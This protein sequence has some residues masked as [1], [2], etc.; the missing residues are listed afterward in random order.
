MISSVA[1]SRLSTFY[2]YLINHNLNKGLPQN[3]YVTFSFQRA[4]AVYHLFS[5]TRNATQGNFYYINTN[6]KII[7]SAISFSGSMLWN[8]IPRSTRYSI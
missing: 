2:A 6:K 4:D 8:D 5:G 7:N 1:P 3:R